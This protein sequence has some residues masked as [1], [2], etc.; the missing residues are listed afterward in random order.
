MEKVSREVAEQEVYAWLDYKKVSTKKRESYKEHTDTLVDAIVDGYL[1]LNKDD[2]SFEH[3]LK[4]P[5]EGEMLL[6]KL[7]YKPRLKVQ[8]VHLHLQNV[9][10]NDADGRLC[11]YI[12]ALTS[13]PKELV[14]HLDSEDYSIGQS[15]AIFFL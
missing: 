5:T 9:K 7:T 2:M 13:K 11:A 8:T 1:S 6:T 14:K 4:F 15:I 10:S 3:T 12:A